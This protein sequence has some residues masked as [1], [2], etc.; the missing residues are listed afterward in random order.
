M[1][2]TMTPKQAAKV[3]LLFATTKIV[4][5]TETLN[6]NLP[7]NA[8]ESVPQWRVDLVRQALFDLNTA[9]HRA[10]DAYERWRK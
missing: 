6:N 1:S 8:L 10:Q 5:A 2:D 4:R 7:G 9:V 3:D